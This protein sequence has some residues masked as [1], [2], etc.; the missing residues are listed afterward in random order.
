MTPRAALALTPL[1]ALSCAPVA[2]PHRANSSTITAS[3]LEQT[4]LAQYPRH[5]RRD[6]LR[7]LLL[8]FG[9][10]PMDFTDRPCVD[11]DGNC[12]EHRLDAVFTGSD[13]PELPIFGVW[14]GYYEGHSY[15]LVSQQGTVE[16]GERPIPSPDG[17]FLVAAASSDSHPPD[18]GITL[19]RVR[20]GGAHPIRH[21]PTHALT[22]YSD[23]RWIGSS[24]VGLSASV[25]DDGMYGPS[26]P[27]YLVE[28]KPEWQLTRDAGTCGEQGKATTKPD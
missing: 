9:G 13:A 19:L 27:F 11:H 1:L 18:K 17:R 12:V 14:E 24:C 28:A 21:I 8:D 20:Y 15:A 22:N 3:P 16:T 4:L 23:L 6:G 2:Q 10:E 7:L 26:E 5:A 25:T